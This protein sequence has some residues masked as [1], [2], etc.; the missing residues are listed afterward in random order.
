MI[1]SKFAD[2]YEE[3]YKDSYFQYPKGRIIN[4]KRNLESVK[5]EVIIQFRN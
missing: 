3:E 4:D 2:N 1:Y 5:I